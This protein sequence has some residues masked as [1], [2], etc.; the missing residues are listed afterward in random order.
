M[1]DVFHLGMKANPLQNR[2]KMRISVK[3]SEVKIDNSKGFEQCN[4]ATNRE[5][6]YQW[7]CNNSKNGCNFEQVFF[8]QWLE[9]THTHHYFWLFLIH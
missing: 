1:C 5:C 9:F 2:E 7:N 4:L 3:I 6:K 8:F